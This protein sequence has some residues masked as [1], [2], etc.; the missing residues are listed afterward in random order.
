MKKLLLG[1][2][3][4][5]V[6]AVTGVWLYADTVARQAVERGSTQAFGTSTEVGLVT[7]GFLD[8]SIGISSYR[9]SGASGFQESSLLSVDDV[10]LKVGYGGLGRERVQASRLTVSGLELNLLMDAGGSNFGPVLRNIRNLSGGGSGESNAPRFAI[11]K[12]QLQDLAVN[13]DVPGVQRSLT[14]P[15]IELSEVGGEDGVWLSELAAIVLGAVMQ[16]T[17]EQADLPPALRTALSGGLD[18]LPAAI[19]REAKDRLREQLDEEA[20]GLLDRATDALQGDED[21][22]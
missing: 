4:V 21:D 17:V 9:V 18:D 3:F 20:R 11:S 16:H 2:A 14:L 1:I 6:A 10:D 7:L 15:D 19:G 13:I 5:L 22:G 8:A 12:V